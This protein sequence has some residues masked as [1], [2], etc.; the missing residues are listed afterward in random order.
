MVEKFEIKNV[1][2]PPT[3]LDDLTCSI[4]SFILLD[5]VECENCGTP[6]CR[7]CLTEWHKKSLHCP[8]KCGATLVIKPGHRFLR[9]MVEDLNVKCANDPCPITYKISEDLNHKKICQFHPEICPFSKE[10][11]KK[12]IRRADMEQHVMTCEHKVQYCSDCGEKSNNVNGEKHNCIK[13]LTSKILELNLV[14]DSLMKSYIN[15]E[16]EF[17]TMKEKMNVLLVSIIYKCDHG[18]NLVFRANWN[19]TCS[20]CGVIKKC[21][22]WEC[23]TCAKCYCLDC[24]KLICSKVCPNMHVFS[25]NEPGHYIC[26]KCGAKK[27]NNSQ[28]SIHDRI[29]EF[30]LC[31]NC[32]NSMF[33]F[34]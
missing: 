24:I 4:C 31:E 17:L 1:I 16:K 21:T 2:D 30:D 8:L 33:K 13:T 7:D 34:R 14:N 29:C 10:G 25:N 15:L 11:C 18:H 19:E 9:R 22:R 28:E 20:C 12:L 3:N 5:I 26:D 6:Y 23:L 32:A 27:S